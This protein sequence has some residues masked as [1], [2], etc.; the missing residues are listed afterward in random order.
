[1]GHQKARIRTPLR[2]TEDHHPHRPGAHRIYLQGLQQT[3]ALVN[4]VSGETARLQPGG[5]EKCAGGIEAESPRYRFTRYLPESGEIPRG[6]IDGET[7][8][9]IVTSVRRI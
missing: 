5:E 6:G 2:Q 4:P 8:N 7:G 9:A 1:M 3:R